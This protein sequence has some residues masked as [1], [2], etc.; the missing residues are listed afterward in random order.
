PL[1]GNLPGFY[2]P[3]LDLVYVL[4]D[5]SWHL[6]AIASLAVNVL[7]FT[8]VSLFSEP[9]AEEQGAAE[10]CAVDNVRRPQ[11][12]ELVAA[13]PQE[14]AAELAKPLGARTAQR[15]VEQALRDL[16]LPFDEQRPYALR[17]LRDRIE[18]NLSGLM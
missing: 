16:G 2:L 4:D 7:V 6:A 8:L 14:F 10:T 11:R 12:R 9:S 13:S 1:I 5:T 3:L 15:E 18:A 17:R